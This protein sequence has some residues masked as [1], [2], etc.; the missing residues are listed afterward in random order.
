MISSHKILPTIAISL[1]L[2]ASPQIVNADTNDQNNERV[3]SRIYVSVPAPHMGTL[4]VR[5]VIANTGAAPVDAVELVF[6]PIDQVDGEVIPGAGAANAERRLIGAVIPTDPTKA[7]RSDAGLAGSTQR[8][9]LPAGDYVLSQVRY[10]YDADGAE[11]SQVYCLSAG[12]MVFHV[13]MMETVFMGRLNLA[14]P[15][16]ATADDV[17]RPLTI[18]ERNVDELRGWRKSSLGL[19]AFEARPTPFPATQDMC[20]PESIHTAGWVSA[21]G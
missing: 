12:S 3:L 9:H 20:P 8:V 17:F 16:E 13:G 15:R 14:D 6:A 4:Y 19:R 7:E 11:R 18:D 1:L 21:D 2:A 10:R 5:P